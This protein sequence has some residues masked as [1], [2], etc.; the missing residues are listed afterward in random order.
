MGQYYVAIIL[1]EKGSPEFVR[2]WVGPS[3]AK[4][5]EHSYLKNQHVLAVEHLLSRKGMFYKSRL[6]WAGD[7]A[8][9]EKETGENLY[10]LVVEKETEKEW[11]T[12][13]SAD[14]RYIVNHTKKLF[15]D[16]MSLPNCIHPLPLLTSEGNGAGG[17]DFRG[18]NDNQCGE[19]ARDVIS[20]EDSAP[21]GYTEF[22]ADFEE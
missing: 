22:T 11:Q 18:R 17:G 16:K 3:G 7:Y 9:P 20:V 4:L 14:Y 15:I 5:M 12:R 6:V 2:T 21:E 10:H 8:E 1:G 19:W 13:E